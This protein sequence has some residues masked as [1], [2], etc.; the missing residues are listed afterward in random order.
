[1]NEIDSIFRDDYPVYKRIDGP[2]IGLLVAAIVIFLA[3]AIAIPLLLC[4]WRR[5]QQSTQA[6]DQNEILSTKP[7]GERP[8]PI[9]IEEQPTKFYETQVNNLDLPRKSISQIDPYVPSPN[10][11][12]RV[13]QYYERF[14]YRIII[15]FIDFY[16]LSEQAKATFKKN[17]RSQCRRIFTTI[18][19]HIEYLN[20]FA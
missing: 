5:Y 16:F 17:T 15:S 7:T 4:C 9:Q 10:D 19:R 1:M 11:V 13:H 14:S 12:Q 2:W 8:I 20:K 6:E 3:A 18:Q